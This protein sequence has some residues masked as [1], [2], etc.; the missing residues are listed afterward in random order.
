MR[1]LPINLIPD[2][3]LSKLT[4]APDFNNYNPELQR[5]VVYM[6]THRQ[7]D[8][9]GNSFAG[10]DILRRYTTGA[11]DALVSELDHIAAGLLRE[12]VAAGESYI[13]RIDIYGQ[14]VNASVKITITIELLDG[15]TE[16]GSFVLNE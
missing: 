2:S 9:Q 4:L 1:D 11:L 10:W 3:R 12:E 8:E 6:L 16:E 7:I 13:N 15:T 14:L 5:V